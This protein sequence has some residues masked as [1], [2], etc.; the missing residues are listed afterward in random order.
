ME[1]TA[2]R[3]FQRW[4]GPV[5][6]EPETRNGVQNVKKTLSCA[7]LTLS[8][9]V[10]LAIGSQVDA[11][12]PAGRP[13][14]PGVRIIDLKK[15]F[16]N[17]N[18]FQDETKGLKS[19][20]LAREEQLKGLR[21]EMKKLDDLR[22]E[23][24]AGSNEAKDI[25]TRMVRLDSEHRSQLTLGKKEFLEKEAKIYYNVYREVLDEVKL[26]SRYEG[27]SL[28]LRFNN[29]PTP[30]PEDPQ[31]VL[32]ELNKSVVHYD[33]SIDITGPILNE[34]NRRWG[35]RG[36]QTQANQKP[37]GVPPRR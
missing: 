11:Q 24:P 23:H 19:E 31:G 18:R 27:V 20:V 3:R 35:Q 28:V 7:M 10:A 1:H 37:S 33:P 17:Y 21:D 25:E 34:L 22:K 15:I 16:D 36:P 6:E 14:L 4:I 5:K 30:G 29:D 26:Y 8:T 32:K 9:V 12:A 13:A 2:R